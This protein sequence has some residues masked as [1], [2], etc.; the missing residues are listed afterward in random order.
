MV[1]GGC[2]GLR[3]RE[4]EGQVG[5]E[6]LLQ[7][8]REACLG[9]AGAACRGAAIGGEHSVRIEAGEPLEV[10]LAICP[11]GW[12]SLVLLLRPH[13]VGLGDVGGLILPPLVQARLIVGQGSASL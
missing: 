1:G 11:A 10:L 3:R 2:W 12:D 7:G 8:L 4:S 5:G 9:R 6:V 13:A